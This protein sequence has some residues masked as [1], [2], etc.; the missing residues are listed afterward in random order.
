MVSIRVGTVVEVRY[1]VN[2]GGRHPTNDEPNFKNAD[3]NY[4]FAGPKYRVKFGDGKIYWMPQAHLRA[5]GDLEYWAFE[6][7]E[8]VLVLCVS[9]D[10]MQ[11]IV[12][13]AVSCD[14]FRPPVGLDDQSIDKRPWRASVHRHRYQDGRLWEYDRYLH[15]EL[16][17][18]QDGT[19][20]IR[21]F[22]DDR[23]DRT[24]RKKETNSDISNAPPRHWEFFEVPGSWQYEHLWD[25]NA[26]IHHRHW[27]WPDGARFHDYT[28]DYANATHTYTAT[29]A[30]GTNYTYRWD[31]NAATHIRTW[32]WPDGYISQYLWDAQSDLHNRQDVHDDGTLF[33]Y[34]HAAGLHQHESAYADGTKF[35]YKWGDGNVWRWQ[36]SDGT[37]IEYDLESGKLTVNNAIGETEIKSAGAI[38]AE[39]KTSITAKAPD[40]VLEGRVQI[41]GSLTITDTPGTD[42]PLSA[43]VND[44]LISAVFGGKVMPYHQ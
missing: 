36:F 1:D 30:D 5:G 6:E 19:R 21:W 24:P 16:S 8:Q 39:S 15:R 34:K 23:E 35:T 33:Q 41:K 43:G 12:L 4:H 37:L 28:W 25:E 9:G 31:E 44:A 7:G 27:L 14:T 13:A 10:P 17:V 29:H 22:L 20:H 42:I 32:T 40:L 2:H 3:I 18:F 38:L 11:S 26:Q